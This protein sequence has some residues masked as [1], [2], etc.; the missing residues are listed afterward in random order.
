MKNKIIGLF[1]M[2]TM[3]FGL[4]V[5]PTPV[6]ADD[7]WSFNIFVDNDV[8]PQ[9]VRVY[10][11]IPIPV[12][13]PAYRLVFF[14]VLEFGKDVTD[15]QS[16]VPGSV[17]GEILY[18]GSTRT[19]INGNF[20]FEPF[21]KGAGAAN[22]TYIVRIAIM[23]DT[24]Q[25]SETYDFFDISDIN[26][27]LAAA[28]AAGTPEALRPILASYG[29]LLGLGERYNSLG[30]NSQV[31]LA[32]ILLAEGS[33]AFSSPNALV[34]AFGRAYAV[35]NINIASSGAAV[36]I[37]L[38]RFSA[39]IDITSSP[40]HNIF[41]TSAWISVSAEADIFNAIAAKSDYMSVSEVLNRFSDETVLVAVWRAQ[42]VG[43]AD[44]VIE[45]AVNAGVV[46]VSY[47]TLSVRSNW[48]EHLADNVAGRRFTDVPR[49]VT[50]INS[51][52][53]AGSGGTGIGGGGGGM[54]GGGGGGGGNLPHPILVDP[55][56]LS[57]NID[58]P[59]TLPEVQ[60]I[61][62]DMSDLIW[63]I[64]A[65]N[66]LFERGI[67]SG[68]PSGNFDPNDFVTREEFTKMI[69][70]AMGLTDS[71]TNIEFEDVPANDWSHSYVSAAVA[72]G[73]INGIGDG[74]FGHGRFISR[75]D[76]SV[77]IYRIARNLEIEMSAEEPPF[78]DY[79]EAGD[80]A[81]DAIAGVYSLG[82]MQG[83]GNRMFNPNGNSTRAEAAVVIHRFLSLLG[84]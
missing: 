53:N 27:F 83:S 69:V 36:R 48:L 38:D 7:S 13:N 54:G 20:S 71:F 8:N 17:R 52:P 3:V 12:A 76:M 79:N 23:G 77:I 6:Y 5:A 49:L 2:V 46:N 81:L 44:R 30:F 14:Q 1:V 56:F 51:I 60:S 29:Y 57:P 39:W 18:F 66:N 58:L 16:V 33:S 37:A 73:L 21:V 59:S 19:D 82:I 4:F 41:T 70:G 43:I 28:A 34:A 40:V 22:G 42:T 9:T 63:A 67:V 78:D 24:V 26:V 47:S 35:E 45:S 74:L 25:Y 68:R 55:E 50:A 64:P 80:Y 75:Q 10:S 61:F 72:V 15:L 11:T 32:R 84:R 31:S 65:V 62:P